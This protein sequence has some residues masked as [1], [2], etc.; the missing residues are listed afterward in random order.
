MLRTARPILL[1]CGGALIVAGGAGA[2]TVV[3]TARADT[4][5]GTAKADRLSGLGGN[6][7][8]FGLAGNDT[9]AG[10]RGADVLA[11]G[12]G[13]D[14]AMAGPG[15][16]I[17]AD[18][19]IVRGLPTLSVTGASVNEGDGGNVAAAQLTFTIVR[20]A[21]SHASSVRYTTA[22]GSATAPADYA[23]ASGT[24]RFAP[25]ETSQTVQIVVAGDIDVEGEETVALRL[26]GAIDAVIAVASA[27]GTIQNDDRP[28]P[29]VGVYNGQTSQGRSV[30][31]EVAGDW[32]R[33]T[34]IAVWVDI[35]CTNGQ[36][37]ANEEFAFTNVPLAFGAWT[38]GIEAPLNDSGI[39]G[40]F[41]LA[42][43]LT[44]PGNASGT[45]KFDLV[46]PGAGV[47]CTTGSV[48]W[49]AS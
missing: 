13:R 35:R 6:D 41:S 44:A 2:A 18:C 34:R 33:L 25:G 27:T 22:D 1:A 9:L 32:S 24:I 4:L 31:F 49:S 17:G 16:R 12:P 43:A 26:S 23:L 29:R 14:V 47:A 8:L 45:V 11:C 38:F 19:E 37:F 39:L 7:R 46:A 10:G 5:R 30:T 3:G 28:R 42:G 15:D 48:S 40:H 20:S 21:A 36:V